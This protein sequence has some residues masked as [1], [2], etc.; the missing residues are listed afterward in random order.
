MPNALDLKKDIL[1]ASIEEDQERVAGMWADTFSY[2][3][4]EDSATNIMRF[5]AA[6]V[7]EGDFQT[8]SSKDSDFGPP[9]NV[10]CVA[11]YL[12]HGSRIILDAQELSRDNYKKFRSFFK[13]PKDP[14]NEKAIKRRTAATHFFIKPKS[15][16]D[17]YHEGK[18]QGLGFLKLPNY[19]NRSN[20]GANIAMG[21]EGRVNY[22]DEEIRTDGSHGHVYFHTGKKAVM[23]GLEQTAPSDFAKNARDLFGQTHSGKGASDTF[24]AAHSLYF[25]NPIYFTKLAERSA[26]PPAKYDGMRVILTDDNFD[27]ILESFESLKSVQSN[28][29]R[30]TLLSQ[31]RSSKNAQN[32]P[33]LVPFFEYFK[34]ETFDLIRDTFWPEDVKESDDELNELQGQEESN[35][36]RQRINALKGLV[37][38]DKDLK[39]KSIKG[40][41]DAIEALISE[42]YQEQALNIFRSFQAF[43]ERYQ[44]EI[45]EMIKEGDPIVYENQ[46]VSEKPHASLRNLSE[47]TDFDDSSEEEKEELEKN[48][49]FSDAPL[50]EKAL[51]E[52]QQKLLARLDDYIQKRQT[53]GFNYSP[54]FFGKEHFIFDSQKASQ[55]ANVCLARVLRRRLSNGT[56]KPSDLT[57][58][59]LKDIR[60]LQAE[61]RNLKCRERGHTALNDIIGDLKKEFSPKKKVKKSKGPEF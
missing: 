55:E 60:K 1:G 21:G 4:D 52:E 15:Q 58:K 53:A 54:G 37:R 56:L 57:E 41:I 20:Y 31:P 51:S 24:T 59:S 5:L 49:D 16:K 36:I 45:E 8:R 13:N 12:S 25:D 26:L 35:E 32:A 34:D 3:D 40:M 43:L 48:D 17:F 47:E 7:M 22:I 44:T 42:I 2:N 18:V 19:V 61:G 14:E 29:T 6:C 11:D 23:V 10:L 38:N 39:V 50:E 46:V 30:N 28:S 27:Q 33:S 9:N